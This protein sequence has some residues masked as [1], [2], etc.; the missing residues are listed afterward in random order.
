MSLFRITDASVEPLSLAEARHHLRVDHSVDDAEISAMV[1]AARQ[2]AES[3][4]RRAFIEQTWKLTLDRF[5]CWEIMLPRPRLQSIEEITYIDSQGAEQTLSPSLYRAALLSE[6][7]RLTP[8]YNQ[9]W[10]STREITDAV[11]IEFIAGYG[12][13][14][15]EVPAPIVQA[16]KLM[17]GLYYTNRSSVA[18]GTIAAEI[19]QSAQ[20]LLNP[21]RM[22][23]VD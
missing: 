5:P 3:Y 15:A 13:T 11:T 16:I 19:P 21:F 18:I 9:S 12:S 20:F 23:G 1:T 8:A 6:P 14:A 4:T 17:L 2:S 7:G 22:R 10:P